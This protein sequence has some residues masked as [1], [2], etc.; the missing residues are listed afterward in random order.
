MGLMKGDKKVIH[1]IL[2]WLGNNLEEIKKRAYLAQFLVKLEVPPEIL[3]DP[4][5]SYLYEQYESSIEEF[6]NGHKESEALKGTGTSVLELKSDI[7]AMEGEKDIVCK[8]IEKLKK[9]ASINFE[10]FII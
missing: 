4:D 9:R 10:K 6:K 3:G 8:K 2:E 7:S 1:P 5:I